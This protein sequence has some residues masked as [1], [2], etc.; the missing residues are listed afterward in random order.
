MDDFDRA[1][2]KARVAAELGDGFRVFPARPDGHRQFL[3][4]LAVLRAAGVAGAA[5]LDAR[6]LRKAV[7]KRLDEHADDELAIRRRRD[8]PLAARSQERVRLVGLVPRRHP[9]RGRPQF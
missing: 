1:V 6:S 7:V 8:L 9:A 5:E 2:L 4:L 3:S